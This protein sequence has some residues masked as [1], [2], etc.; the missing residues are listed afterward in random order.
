MKI[1]VSIDLKHRDLPSSALI[2][3]HLEKLG[4]E[5]RFCSVWDEDSIMKNFKADAIILPKPV[6]SSTLVA[7]W[8][9]KGI[10]TISLNTEGNPQDKHYQYH[11]PVATDLLITWNEKQKKSHLDFFK[12]YPTSTYGMP[13]VV[14]LGCMRLDLHHNKH[15][16]LFKDS[17]KDLYRKFKLEEGKKIITIATSTQ[18]A[19]I[20]EESR[21][22]MNQRRISEMEE[23]AS[24]WDIVRSHDLSREIMTDTLSVV[25][26]VPETIV[27]LKPHPNESIHF[28][29]ETIQK[30]D[31]QNVKLMKGGTIQELLSISDLHIANNVCTTTFEAKLKQIPTIE[32]NTELSEKLYEK[33]HLEIADY[34]SYSS[35]E[36]YEA[37]KEI[38][39]SDKPREKNKQFEKYIYEKYG[40][41]DGKRCEAYAVKIDSFLKERKVRSFTLKEKIS[42]S[43]KAFIPLLKINFWDQ[44]LFRLSIYK[45]KII[46]YFNSNSTLE[47][48]SRNEESRIR[49]EPKLQKGDENY[50]LRLYKENLSG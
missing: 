13:D 27:I 47:G 49:F 33:E 36:V 41:F 7:K 29:K 24:Y 34:R 26:K 44:P 45:K 20:P 4:H 37:V 23:S 8:K 48:I 18:D 9:L 50:W 35:L 15:S 32:I 6:F 38:F 42:L 25:S 17:K 5:V 22:V 2:G 31:S 21:E 14:N 1:L 28:L 11:I 40:L 30:L 39:F 19:D 43:K 16:F 3:F 12:K 46:A 10:T